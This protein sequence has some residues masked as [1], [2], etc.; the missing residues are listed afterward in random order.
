MGA[1][2]PTQPGRGRA[3]S[4]LLLNYQEDL[5][6]PFRSQEKQEQL[7]KERTCPESPGRVRLPDGNLSLSTGYLP[8]PLH[9]PTKLPAVFRQ[10]EPQQRVRGWARYREGMLTPGG[11]PRAASAWLFSSREGADP[12]RAAPPH[13]HPFRFC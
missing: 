11:C 3:E 5:G 9:C 4:V 13:V 10:G 12:L 7:E 8:V 2:F 1:A 6:R